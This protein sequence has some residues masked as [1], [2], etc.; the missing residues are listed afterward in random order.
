LSAALTRLISCVGPDPWTDRAL[1][2]ADRCA[3]A[4]GLEPDQGARARTAAAV[5]LENRAARGCCVL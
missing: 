2:L 5:E 3:R 1:C 4:Y